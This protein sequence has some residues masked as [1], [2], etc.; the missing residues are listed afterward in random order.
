MKLTKAI[1]G[2][3]AT[4]K[5]PVDDFAGVAKQLTDALQAG[6]LN[7]QTSVSFSIVSPRGNT[8]D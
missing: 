1:A 5:N 4:N 6:K 8:A 2:L 7:W 3:V